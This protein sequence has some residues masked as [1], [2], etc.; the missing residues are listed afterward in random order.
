[1]Y[2]F[3]TIL[4]LVLLMII[5]LAVFPLKVV[6]AANSEKLPDFYVSFSWLNP[7]IT[8]NIAPS[9]EGF[10]LSVNLLRKKIICRKLK[11]KNTSHINKLDFIRSFKPNHVKIKTSYGFQDMSITGIT[12]AAINIISEFMDLE[13]VNNSPNFIAEHD[14]FE[15]DGMLEMNVLSSLINWLKLKSN[16]NTAKA[17]HLAK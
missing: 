11:G 5:L 7:F 10:M 17:L 15:L 2:V 16:R 6:F 9:D 4:I 8:G 3:T 13:S 14:Y 1:M 12:C